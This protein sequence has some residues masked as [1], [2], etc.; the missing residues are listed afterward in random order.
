MMHAVAILILILI[1]ERLW[2]RDKALSSLANWPINLFWLIANL[3]IWPYL[4]SELSLLP[5]KILPF[6]FFNEALPFAAQLIFG[7]LLLDFVSYWVH[8]LFHRVPFLW[9]IHKVHHSITQLTALS[10]FRHS[11]FELPVHMLASTIVA[12]S[13]SLS[14]EVV[15]ILN[16]CFRFFCIIQHSN[17][18]LKISGLNDV[19]VTPANHALHHSKRMFHPHGQ[20][21]SFIFSFWDRLF[22]TYSAPES[23]EVGELGLSSVRQLPNS[24]WSQFFHPISIFF[25]KRKEQKN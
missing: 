3:L 18:N 17:I 16:S 7:L 4:I 6:S 24:I 20:N 5:Q 14:F 15:F 10:S 22:A 12:N 21:F 9:E 19:L 23:C 1:I 11:W 25:T 13:L 8:F 2:P